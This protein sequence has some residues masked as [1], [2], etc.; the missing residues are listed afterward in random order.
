MIGANFIRSSSDRHREEARPLSP[1]RMEDCHLGGR[2][3]CNDAYLVELGGE[4]A[5]AATAKCD[6]GAR[7]A[8]EHQRSDI[9]QSAVDPVIAEW[10]DL[11]QPHLSTAKFIRG[12]PEQR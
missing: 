10:G 2:D 11:L 12:F 5:I 3:T 7:R 9:H 1:S 8:A 4:S 6:R